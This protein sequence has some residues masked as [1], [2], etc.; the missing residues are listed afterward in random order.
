MIYRSLIIAAISG[1]ALLSSCSS[2]KKAAKTPTPAPKAPPTAGMPGV[3]GMDTARKKPTP[4]GIT[5][6]VKSSK[7]NDGLFRVYQDTATGTIQLYVKK[8]QL[9]KEFIYQSFSIS[10]PNQLFLNQS[11]HRSTFV[12]EPKKVYDK[13]EFISKNTSLYYDESNPVSKTKNVDKPEAVVYTEKI[14][15]EDSAGYLIAAD[16]L[17]VSERL[18]QV[19]PVS[20]PSPLSMFQFNLGSLD[21]SKS[22]V[23]G[24]R[25]YPNN[26]DI[27]VDLAY[28][29][30]MPIN[31]GGDDITDARYNR[32]RMQHTLLEM[33]KNDFVPRLDDPRIGYLGQQVTNLT[34][35]SPVPFRD[36]ISKWYL[37]KKEPGAALSEPTEPIVFWVENTTP[38][39]YRDA[40]VE[41]GHKWNEAF[42]KAGFKN[43]V[44]MKIMPDDANW[45][46]ADVRYNVIRWV[47]SAQP[48]YGA[49]GPSFINPRTGQILGADITVEWF[50]GSAS[51]ILD[52]LL[53]AGP[54]AADQQTATTV[55]P[56]GFNQ[57]AL[58][59]NIAAELKAQ[60]TTGLTTLEM[61]GASAAE[62]KELHKQFLTYL[63]MHEMGH[64][65][66][67]MHNM[68]ASQMLTP[69]EVNNKEITRRLGLQG[70]VMDYPAI[71]IALDR[72][73][74]GD[75]YTTKAGPY[76]LWAIEY[77]Y[78][79]FSNAAE[80]KAALKEILSRSNDPKLTFGN[81]ADDMRSPGG[82]ID[83]RVQVN[84]MSSDVIAYAEDRFKLV[85]NL[86]GNLVKR[87]SKP[88]QSYAELRSRY[89]Q[90]NGQRN[91]MI[92]AVSRYVGGVY[93]D[94][95]FPDQR[96]SNKPFTPVS[97][98]TQ[99]KAIA[100]LAKYV[101]A[102]DAFKQDEQVFPYLQAQRRGYGFFGNTED[103]K[104]T[105]LSTNLQVSPL[106][107]ILHPVTLQ[108][109]SNSRLYGNEYSVAEVMGD[110]SAAIFDADLNGNVNVY[111]QYLQSAFVKG[112][113]NIMD[114]KTPGYDDVAKAGALATLKSVRAKLARATGG[115]EETRAHRAALIYRIDK[116]LKAE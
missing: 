99:K 37:K 17:F 13:I 60:Y 90:L 103:F 95:S 36:L 54:T 85:N 86:M 87:Y 40:I 26:T 23:S 66:G 25:S 111:R 48:T 4:P 102:P 97:K 63:I 7:R 39:E 71:N 55:M 27:I 89:N 110:V 116:A 9:G 77:G 80:E 58:H 24:V 108:R 76:D 41:A 91:S 8:D 14:V 35:I 15:A 106:A 75:Y 3:P 100:T 82:G 107:H 2:S 30:P 43:A 67:L 18:D 28:F 93:I 88:D 92:S 20:I 81:D 46:P 61:T 29:N 42:E 16:G 34:S 105:G 11:M 104:I 6:K 73:K 68:K 21:P 31:G 38:L 74:Q 59:C 83:P 115:N 96:S 98:A 57:H 22:R 114:P 5:D 78:K 62:I 65:L 56:K 33:P 32:I 50:S 10:G 47:S 12:L 51:P 109:I 19:R 70:S 1:A 44:Q 53:T 64:T 94:R 45:D 112:A 49:I 52:E 101:W 79:T 72:K 84:D 113:I 69:E